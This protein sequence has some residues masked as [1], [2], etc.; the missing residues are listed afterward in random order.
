MLS[1]LK[2]VPDSTVPII[3]R[4]QIT[5][6]MLDEPHC[7]RGRIRG[8]GTGSKLPRSPCHRACLAALPRRAAGAACRA[9]RPMTSRCV[10]CAALPAGQATGCVRRAPGRPAPHAARRA[11]LRAA[12]NRASAADGAC[13]AAMRVRRCPRGVRV[14]DRPRVVRGRPGAGRRAPGMPRGERGRATVYKRASA[15]TRRGARECIDAQC[16]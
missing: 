7:S 13:G 4:V 10:A 15:A 16:I 11:W 1:V 6:C 9:T 2:L 14:G 5:I 12:Y 3:S 8:F